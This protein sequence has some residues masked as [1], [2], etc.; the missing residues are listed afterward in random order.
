MLDVIP[1]FLIS[2][3]DS[4]SGL[5]A[6]NNYNIILIGIDTRRADYLGCYGYAKDAVAP[7]IDAF[8]RVVPAYTPPAYF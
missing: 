7:C 2:C 3:A 1:G 4:P 6:Q 5:V 8:A